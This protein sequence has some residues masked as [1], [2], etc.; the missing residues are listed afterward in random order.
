MKDSVKDIIFYG[1]YI[2]FPILFVAFYFFVQ[3][4]SIIKW[5]WILVL[6]LFIYVRFIEPQIIITRQQEIDVWFSHKI[7]LLSDMHLWRYKWENFLQRVVDKINTIDAESVFIAGDLTYEPDVEKLDN[8]FWSLSLINKPVYW[9]L[10]NHDVEK[11]GPKL[12]EELIEALDYENVIFLNND[13]Q[14]MWNFIL[15][16]LWSHWNNEDD[17]SLLNNYSWKD[18]IVTLL[19]NPDSISKFPDGISDVTF[20]WHTHGW[21]I[22]IPFLYQKVIPTQW[23]YDRWYSQEK[24]TKLYI[25]SGLGEIWLPMRF[26]NPPVIDVITLK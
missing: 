5:L 13:V 18:N 23:E 10:G 16:G 8:L 2:I 12:R 3:K 25:S 9:V 24:T 14:D 7:I 20:A 4:K 19:H 15:I 17:A 21:Q 11:P 1:S 22:R 6:L 26:L